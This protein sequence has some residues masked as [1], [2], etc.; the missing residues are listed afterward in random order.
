ML[1]TV[2]DCIYNIV[3]ALDT[4][5]E[6]VKK[7]TPTPKIKPMRGQPAFK[8]KSN[9]SDYFKH[10]MK[11]YRDNGKDYQKVPDQIKEYR[12]K[13]REKLKEKSES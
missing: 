7:F 10:Y 8:N 5:G 6:I 2:A 9:R 3:L 12:R 13:Q 4:E 1:L 11:E